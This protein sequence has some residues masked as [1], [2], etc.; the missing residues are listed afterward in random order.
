[1]APTL[2]NKVEIDKLRKANLL[3]AEVLNAV[4]ESVKPGAT[5]MDL[6]H[7]A[8]EIL[9]RSEAKPAFL[10]YSLGPKVPPYPAVLCTSLNEQVVHGIPS[11]KVLL[12]EGDILS[13]D[14]GVFVDG[15]CG[16]AART[17]PVGSISEKAQRL[18]DAT[19]QALE[20]AIDAM[21]PGNRLRDIGLAIQ[22]HVEALGFSVVRKFVGHGIGRSMHE[23][24]Q[25]PNYVVEKPGR[26]L[27][28]KPG[29]VLAIEPMV[30]E[31]THEVEILKDHWTAVTKDRK[32]SAHF[33]H[34][35]AVTENG[36]LVLSRP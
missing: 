1:M 21:R 31:G 12:K 9:A 34:S 36:P 28:L 33:E 25:V 6:E 29:L 10:G 16:D 27:K 35:V 11:N 13:V 30:N 14:F 7:V 32:L 8:R 19:E 2:K 22:S 4:S 26:G 3:V 17:I 20:K 24:P 23:E 15:Y 5:T 18:L